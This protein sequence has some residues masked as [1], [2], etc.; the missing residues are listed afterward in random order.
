MS[1]PISTERRILT[2]GEFEAVSRTHY[3]ALCGLERPALVELAR[4]LRDFRDK[5]R[6][7]SRHRRREMRGKA[8][9]RGINAAKDESG[10]G[11]KKEVF[12]AA[13][14]RVNREIS[15]QTDL[16]RPRSQG[17]L[18]QEALA[19]RRAALVN[20]RP[21]PG[22]TADGGMRAVPSARR[23]TRPDPRMIGSVSQA[24][25]NAQAR[26]DA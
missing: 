2:P 23:R 8:E 18:S 6:D 19:A 21:A 10:L 13:L 20:H 9:P 24:N 25:K 16:A 5:A 4:T 12:A 3:P 14:K 7:V 15:R 26:K 11:R 1:A 17:E 22:R